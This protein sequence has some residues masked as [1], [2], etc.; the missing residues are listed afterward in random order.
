MACIRRF[1]SLICSSARCRSSIKISLQWRKYYFLYSLN[2]LNKR[3]WK[4]YKCSYHPQHV[5]L[6]WGSIQLYLHFPSY[7]DMRKG[8]Y[9]SFFLVDRK[10]LV[11][12]HTLKQHGCWW[13]GNTWWHQAITWAKVDLSS[14]RS[15]DIHL[16]ASLQEILRLPIIQIS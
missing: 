1:S 9:L 2:T 11:I 13:P 7:V 3:Q 15:N 8:R 4:P 5:E 10:D 16:R 12:L 14:V 6:F